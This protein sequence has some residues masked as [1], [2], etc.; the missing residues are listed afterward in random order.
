MKNIIMAWRNLWRKPWRTIITSGS[1]FFGVLFTAFMT[2]MQYGSYESMIN[3]VVKFY[4]GYMQI[5]TEEYHENKTINNTFDMNDSLRNIVEN[6]K[7]VTH[8][9]PRLEYFA[10]T[11]SDEI[12]KGAIIIGI[13]PEAENNVT[14]LEKWVDEGSYLSSGD[15][16]VL[17]AIDLAKYLNIGIGD[18]LVLYGQGYHGVMAA[19]LYPVKGIL[20]LPFPDMNRSTVYLSIIEAQSFFS[21][22]NQFTGLVFDLKNIDDVTLHYLDGHICVEASLPFKFLQRLEDAETLQIAFD[23][24]T[25]K[26]DYVGES[27][28][29]F[30]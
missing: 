16:G 20:K 26:L 12:T 28:L 11:S 15:D 8:F 13:D 6:E 14:N 1:V 18:T 23:Q 7:E 29:Q 19:G 5:F 4:S 9:T 17:V 2:S 22:G 27:R 30:H 3:N 10:L 24:A 25:K 21:T